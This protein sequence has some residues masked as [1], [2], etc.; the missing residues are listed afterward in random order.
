VSEADLPEA[1][2]LVVETNPIA[3]TQAGGSSHLDPLFNPE[4]FLEKM[5]NMVGNSSRFNNTPMDELL[6]MSLGHEL[7]G[8]LLKY[9]LATRQRQEVAAANDKMALVDKNWPPLKRNMPPLR[10]IFLTSWR[11]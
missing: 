2:G 8:L 9:A 11:Y 6:R 5:V 10:R 4:L 7:K 3:A 1:E